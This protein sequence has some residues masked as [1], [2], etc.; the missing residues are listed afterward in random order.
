M[1]QTRRLGP[2]VLA[3]SV[4][5]LTQSEC[6]A[7]SSAYPA[8]RSATNPDSAIPAPST[9]A[10]TETKHVPT[11]LDLTK[12]FASA[13]ARP[14]PGTP[15]TPGGTRPR[16]HTPDRPDWAVAPR[17][18]LVPKASVAKKYPNELE[19]GSERKVRRHS[20]EHPDWAVAALGE[21]E[22]EGSVM[23]EKR[24]RKEEKEMRGKGKRRRGRHSR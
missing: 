10:R 14:S 22:V 21:H 11:A 23:P 20:L 3:E 18:E 16:V 24:V 1:H 8:P 4:V 9:P 6:L 17:D 15:A 19:E 5:L 13:E 12:D 2:D 7:P